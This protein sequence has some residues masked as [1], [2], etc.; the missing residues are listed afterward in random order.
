[1]YSRRG[2]HSVMAAMAKPVTMVAPFVQ[3]PGRP[4]SATSEPRMPSSPRR[5]CAVVPMIWRPRFQLV[6]RA[7]TS[8]G[9][10]RTGSSFDIGCSAAP[11]AGG[12]RW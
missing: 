7:W 9:I 1:M 6:S 12:A 10:S 3:M 11:G 5:L 4:A 2:F 8:A